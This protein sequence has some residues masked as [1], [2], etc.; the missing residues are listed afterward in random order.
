V[1]LDADD[2]GKTVLCTNDGA[3]DAEVADDLPV[4][5]WCEVIAADED[6]V[7]T[8]IGEDDMTIVAAPSAVT[9]DEWS[10][11]RLL[12]I[13]ANVCHVTGRGVEP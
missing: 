1:V 9:E 11:L 2:L 5:W 12:V 3:T 4:G 6:C 10:T 7:V 13:S 8:V